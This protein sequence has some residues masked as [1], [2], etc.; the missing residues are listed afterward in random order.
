MQVA[1]LLSFSLFLSKSDFG[2]AWFCELGWVAARHKP[3]FSQSSQEN[4]ILH[5]GIWSYFVLDFNIYP[6][7]QVNSWQLKEE[8]WSEENRFFSCS[9]SLGVSRWHSGV[10]KLQNLDTFFA[11]VDFCFHIDSGSF[12]VN[13]S[14]SCFLAANW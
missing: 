6:P 3:F 4:S 10:K 5:A 7:L 8:V 13:L 1:G 11:S 2:K 14:C 12:I 9:A